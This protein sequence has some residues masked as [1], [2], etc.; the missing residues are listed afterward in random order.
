M[1]RDS[2][3]NYTLPAGNPVVGGTT[4]E[5]N[6]ANPTLA[7]I[8][9]AMT[10]SLSRSGA[11]NM[12]QPL[13]SVSGSAG[14]PGLTFAG[15]ASTGLHLAAAGNLQLSVSGVALSRWTGGIAYAKDPTSAWQEVLYNN[16]ATAV[17]G[18]LTLSSLTLASLSLTN[19][20]AVTA[21][22][23][24][25]LTAGTIF[26][27]RLTVPTRL[28]ANSASYFGSSTGFGVKAFGNATAAYLIS[29]IET[30]D[31]ISN[32]PDGPLTIRATALVLG[33]TTGNIN[34]STIGA[35]PV[36]DIVSS[37]NGAIQMYADG[38]WLGRG[39]TSAT[40]TSLSGNVTI[41][42]NSGIL[43][44]NAASFDF[45][46]STSID[47]LAA[48]T[49]TSISAG[50]MWIGSSGG[51]TLISGNTALNLVASAGA[52]SL[53]ASGRIDLN[54]TTNGG[55]V[56]TTAGATGGINLN[57]SSSILLDAATFLVMNT[58]GKADLNLGGAFEVTSGGATTILSSSASISTT[59]S[60]AVN[61]TAG[62]A[63]AVAGV[64]TLGSFGSTVLSS[65]GSTTVKQPLSANNALVIANTAIDLYYPTTT[66]AAINT[67]ST[68]FNLRT[69]NGAL[70]VVANNSSVTIYDNSSTARFVIN[71][72]T[73]TISMPGLRVGTGVT[74]ELYKDGFGNLAITL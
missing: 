10:D 64:L 45:D 67:T 46:S 70:A 55:I 60:G 12:L 71:R 41:N 33:T 37:S 74:G 14:L 65:F 21:I 19:I 27:N 72:S 50:N 11:G 5:A 44:L 51:T 24:G 66:Q 42:A 25:N 18:N 34:F 48:T 23:T 35:S 40:L 69:P 16:K 62:T 56:L 6:W 73:G 38:A 58:T 30:N 31:A 47:I 2:G 29:A 36:S 15:E 49:S 28:I 59:G 13:K 63:A 54:S 1:S 43:D 68:A 7:D 32:V 4:I 61:I 26:T 17:L 22:V 3:G 57:A 9:T 52:A 53:S 20:T 39:T 8:A